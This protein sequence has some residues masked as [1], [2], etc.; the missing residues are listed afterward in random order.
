MADKITIL[1]SEKTTLRHYDQRILF[2]QNDFQKLNW[3]NRDDYAERPNRTQHRSLS[4]DNRACTNHFQP[5]PPL[6]DQHPSI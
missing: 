1:R 4:S 5:L 2:P 6:I 3:I